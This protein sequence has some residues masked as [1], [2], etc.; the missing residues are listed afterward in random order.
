MTTTARRE[1]YISG[2]SAMSIISTAEVVVIDTADASTHTFARFQEAV[3]ER[4]LEKPT[5][6]KL[7][8]EQRRKLKKK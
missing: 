4:T 1:F 8:R 6:T 3:S 2:L 7:N 5:Q